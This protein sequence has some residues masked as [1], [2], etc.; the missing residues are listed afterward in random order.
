MTEAVRQAFWLSAVLTVFLGLVL[1]PFLRRLKLGQKVRADGPARHLVKAGTPTMGGIIFLSATTLTILLLARHQAE[2]VVVL[3]VALSY[4]LIG[5]LDDFLKILKNR[6]LGLRARDKLLAQMLVA[7][8]LAWWACAIAGRGTDYVIPFSG[9]WLAGGWRFDLGFPFFLLF[10][11]LVLV[12]SANAVNLTD[13][14]DGLASTVVALAAGFYVFIA[15]TVDK[16]G[17]AITLAALVGGCLGFLVFNR[18]PAR[19]FMGDTGSL[20]LGS[21]LGTAAVLTRTELFL[22]IVGGVLVAE[23]LSVILQVLSF[24]LTGRRL[25]RMSPLHHHYELKGWSENKVVVVFAFWGLVAGF[26]GWIGLYHLG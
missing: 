19:V 3:L 15:L 18:Y 24:R 6:S 8:G 9:F 23:T 5:F 1:I 2:A 10:T 25:W 4:G 13:G 7:A 22:P 26:L 21:A 11:I 12:G 16:V 20:A 14:L 17:V